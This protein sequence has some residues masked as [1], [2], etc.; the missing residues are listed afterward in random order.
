MKLV[1][2]SPPTTVENEPQ[3]TSQMIT[4]GL[5]HFHLRKPISNMHDFESYVQKLST[6]DRRKI[7]LHSSHE[8]V[9]EWNLK[10]RSNLK[11]MSWSSLAALTFNAALF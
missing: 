11:L 7:I 9:A 10:V 8:L 5:Q 2:I 3:L 4:A 6:A 1:I